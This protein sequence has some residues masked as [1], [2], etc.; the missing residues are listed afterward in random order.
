MLTAPASTD[1]D[2]TF[3]PIPIFKD[4]KPGWITG[5]DTTISDGDFADITLEC[6][7]ETFVRLPD[8]GGRIQRR[9]AE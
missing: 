9:G 1:A 6:G 3:V 5:Y 2:P 7:R 4:G 8:Y